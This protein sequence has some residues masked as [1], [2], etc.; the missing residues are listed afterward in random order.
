MRTI[1]DR[2]THDGFSL[3]ELMVALVIGL[4]TTLIIM[5]VLSAVEGQKRTTIGMA[6]TQ[7][8]GSIA[9]HM[10]SRDLQMAGYGLLPTKNANPHRCHPMPTVDHDKNPDSAKIPLMPVTI[11]DGGDAAGGSD[12]LS[13]S[14]GNTPFGGS[15]S[16]IT[17]LTGSRVTIGSNFGCRTDDIALLING[18]ACTTTHVTDLGDPADDRSVGLA[19]TDAVSV[20]RSY[21]S[22]LGGWGNKIYR[23]RNGAL[24]A[25]GIPLISGIVALRA[26]YGIAAKTDNNQV[27]SWISAAQDPWNRVPLAVADRN[28]IKALRIAVVARSDLLEKEVVSS[29]CSSTT[30]SDPV[31]TGICAWTGSDDSPAPT[32]D[33]SDT[34]DW[35]HYRYR[36]FETIIPLRNVVWARSLL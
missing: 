7:T 11:T 36:V 13:I 23:V 32:V 22:C 35:N 20:G 27:T 28:R 17:A 4:L 12:T 10:I 29:A 9:L 16:V 18:S 6:D 19:S 15:P 1:R 3:V 34:T 33:L 24:E 31:P 5:Q 2:K 26:Q 14:F 21:L 30:V 25:N 8:N